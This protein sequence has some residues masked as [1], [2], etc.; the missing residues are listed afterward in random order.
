MADLAAVTYGAVIVAT[1]T[2]TGA[3]AI[4]DLAGAPFV[5]ANSAEVGVPRSMLPTLALVKGAGAVGLLVGA[6]WY[7]PL[8]IAASAGLT[9]FFIGAAIAHI[10]AGVLHNIAFPATFLAFATASLAL[11]LLR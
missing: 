11:S 9:A 5:L 7:P 2:M 1:V 6:L 8:A 10:R 4:A 3:I